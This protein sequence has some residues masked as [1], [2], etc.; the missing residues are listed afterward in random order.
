[1]VTSIWSRTA[2]AI[3]ITWN[4]F[5]GLT[6]LWALLK[7]VGLVFNVVGH[8]AT[9]AWLVAIFSDPKGNMAT[10]AVAWA[11]SFPWWVYWI[12]ILFIVV[13]AYAQRLIDKW[14]QKMPSRSV[15]AAAPS[16][17]DATTNRQ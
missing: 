5:A 13:A 10:R 11:L 4:W 12:P 3:R 7:G 16:V 15:V 6:A 14:L 17:H 1:V 2:Y 8:I 9:V